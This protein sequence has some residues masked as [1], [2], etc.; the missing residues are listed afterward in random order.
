MKQ[1]KRI[2]TKYTL[3]ALVIMLNKRFEVK[4]EP[5]YVVISPPP[6]THEQLGYLHAEC[7]PVYT[8]LLLDTGEIE[9]YSEAESKYYLKVLINYGDWIKFRGKIVFNPHSFEKATT[10]ILSQA[11]DKILSECALNNYHVNPPKGVK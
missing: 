9:K 2:I 11:I 4:D 7:L 8:Q 5:L 3:P 1:I 6:K 10:E